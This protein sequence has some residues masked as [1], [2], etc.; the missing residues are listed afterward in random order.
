MI[1]GLP[2]SLEVLRGREFRLLFSAQ[3]VSVLGDQMVAVALAF[4]VLEIGGSVAGVGLVLGAGAFALVARCSV[5]GVV[6]DRTSRRG[7]MVAADLV[8]VASQGA[9]RPC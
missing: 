6:A 3:A 4:A 5:G 2:H 1:P 8:R 9:R 7:V